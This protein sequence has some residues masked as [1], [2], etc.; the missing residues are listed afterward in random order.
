MKFGKWLKEFKA[1]MGWKSVAGNTKYI[2]EDYEAGM[3]PEQAARKW[4]NEGITPSMPVRVLDN[5][6][7]SL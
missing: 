1:L 6:L 5:W 3:T 2:K 7:R 4:R